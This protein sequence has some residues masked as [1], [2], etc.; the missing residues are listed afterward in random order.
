MHILLILQFS[1]LSKLLQHVEIRIDID[2]AI[3]YVQSSH[4]I[5]SD[6][7]IVSFIFTRDQ[8]ELDFELVTRGSNVEEVDESLA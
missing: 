1:V 5:S 4:Q 2:I 6:D 8:I 7:Q 3:M